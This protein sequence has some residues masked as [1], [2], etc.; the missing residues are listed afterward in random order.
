VADSGE[1]PEVR[2]HSVSPF[3]KNQMLP[4]QWQKL[5]PLLIEQTIVRRHTDT[6]HLR[7]YEY[8]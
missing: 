2:L 7:G 6:F 4:L 5:A 3:D 8:G 1:E